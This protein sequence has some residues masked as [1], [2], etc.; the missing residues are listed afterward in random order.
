MY[1]GEKTKHKAVEGLCKATIH[2]TIAANLTLHQMTT[3]QGHKEYEKPRTVQ[4]KAAK[5]MLGTSR[6]VSP[7]II[8]MELGWTPIDANIIATKLR[9]FEKLKLRVIPEPGSEGKDGPS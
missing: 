2:A 7:H 4:A 6:R 8:L 3:P 9:F 5:N 1:Q